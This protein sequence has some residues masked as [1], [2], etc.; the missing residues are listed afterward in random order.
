MFIFTLGFIVMG[1]FVTFFNYVTFY[2]LAPPFE[3]RM[4]ILGWMYILYIFGSYSSSFFGKLG[5]QKPRYMTTAFALCIMVIGFL[6]TFVQSSFI[7]LIA[8][9]FIIVGFFGAHA[10]C[11]AWVGKIV[12]K[13][14]SQASSLYLFFYY[15][16]ASIMGTFGGIFY[17]FNG[18]IGVV[19]YL[20]L[21]LGFGLISVWRLY[22]LLQRENQSMQHIVENQ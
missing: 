11:S 19:C 5:D 18:W 3:W 21:A 20:L 14:K 8:T 16:G 2:L 9:I 15:M 7:I 4:W 13:H 6:L 22:V 17:H 10:T 12:S 1:V